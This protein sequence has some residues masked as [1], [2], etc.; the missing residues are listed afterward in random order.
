MSDIFE[1]LVSL[2]KRRGF[3]FPSSDIYG[4]LS[5]TYDYG[6]LG[7]ELKRNV[8]GRW[9]EAMV[10]QHDNIEGLDA[11]ILMH[12][13]VWRASGHVEAFN[14]PLID[15]RVS[16]MRYRA[17][18]LIE[19][20]VERLRRQGKEDRAAAVL[21]RLVAAL[22]AADM[23]KALYAII[24]E[25]EIKSPDSGAFD[26][27]EVRQF[28]LMFS[29]HVG[30]V[31]DEESR[32]YLR[33][34]TAQ[35][36]FVNFHNVR[37][38]ARLQVPFGIAQIGK[39]F[40]NEIVAR[41]FIF[42]MREFEQMEM[43]YFVKPGTQ[44][45]AFELW[46]ERRMQWHLDNG[47]RASK[48]RW[49]V[50][51]KL[52]HYAD[53]AQDVQYQ[54]PIGWQEVEGIHS[55]TDYDLRRHQEFSGKKME[56]FDQQTNER[57]IPY[58]VETSV[59]LDRTILMLLSEAYTEEEVNGDQRT[60]LKFHPRI[61]P[62]KAAVFPLVKKDGMPEIAH[63]IEDDLRRN[64]NVF[65]DEKGAVGRRYRRMD[66][67]GTPFCITVD[68][69][70]VEEGTVTVRDRDTM[71]QVRIPKD[72]VAAYVFDKIRNWQRVEG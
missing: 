8:Q 6:P 62:I 72:N 15:D 41:Q 68:G 3:I 67:I 21:D 12:P 13:T 2:C 24:M 5:A 36:I 34:E 55:R 48:L 23:P 11:A 52:A 45:E 53:A 47:V 56:Y 66:E 44:M 26:W 46:R 37:E 57:Y 29:T 32:I 30:P 27:T 61:A 71:E 58:V 38:T 4:G 25:E 14:D 18:Q 54:Y 28:N 17:D 65:Y 1:K 49:H 16:K 19:G 51:E 50:H 35:G 63:A 7:V 31:A 59:G 39:A 20:H 64:Y 70:T 60:V 10:Y 69:E 43:Q 22:N 9:W 42:R 40:R 33:P